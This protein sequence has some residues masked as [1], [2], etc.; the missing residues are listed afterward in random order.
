M[1]KLILLTILLIS[2]IYSYGQPKPVKKDTAKVKY[3]YFVQIPVQDYQQ[4]ANAMNEYKR[5]SIYDP[6]PADAQKVAIFKSIEA[7]LKDLPGRVKLD[8]VKVTK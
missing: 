4:L 1:K 2:A 8:S 5:L 6:L 3:S 7:Y